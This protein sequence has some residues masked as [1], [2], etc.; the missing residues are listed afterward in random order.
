MATLDFDIKYEVL[1]TGTRVVENVYIDKLSVDAISDWSIDEKLND[2]FKMRVYVPAEDIYKDNLLLEREITIPIIN[3]RG[4]ITGVGDDNGKL[5]II[6]Q[7]V[8][9]HFKRRIFETGGTTNINVS[10]AS[11]SALI[12]TIITHANSDMPFTWLKGENALTDTISIKFDNFTHFKALQK[13]AKESGNDLWFEQDRVYIG[14]RGKVIDVTGDKVFA[15]KL[16]N[17]LDLDQYANS[18]KV[19][20]KKTGSTRPEHV[21]SNENTDLT[22][23]YEK[24][25]VNRDLTSTSTVTEAAD[26]LLDE[27]NILTPDVKISIP[28]GKFKEYDIEIGDVLKMIKIDSINKI[29]GFYRIVKQKITSEKVSLVLEYSD[30]ARFIPR[31]NDSNDILVALL[32]KVRQLNLE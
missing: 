6:I 3:K 19:I 30:T 4:V 21:S 27:F 2:I 31:L 20:G 15:D 8:A 32:D 10:N 17:F 12:S 13:I 16:N 22:Y 25:V 29:A 26:R 18:L 5:L 14:Q 11:I 7:G 9:W 28:L 1:Q 23:T 24:V